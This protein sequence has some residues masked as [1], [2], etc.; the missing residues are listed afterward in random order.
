MYRKAILKQPTQGF[1]GPCLLASLS[2]QFSC[3]PRLIHVLPLTCVL[4]KYNSVF[5][6]TEEQANRI[7]PNLEGI[8]TIGESYYYAG[9]LGL[10][11][12]DEGNP[13]AAGFVERVFRRAG[14]CIGEGPQTEITFPFE[15]RQRLIFERRS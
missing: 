6:V 13:R 5:K 10:E 12:I 14:H 8:E 11:L 7:S 9:P 3:L 4:A 1:V 2:S 15:R